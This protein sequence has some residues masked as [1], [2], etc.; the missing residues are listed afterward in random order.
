MIEE[1]THV[2]Y[3]HGIGSKA[4]LYSMQY[5]L[6]ISSGITSLEGKERGTKT[7][8]GGPKSIGA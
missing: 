6:I 7:A 2:K 4:H 1:T 3:L 5:T 8:P